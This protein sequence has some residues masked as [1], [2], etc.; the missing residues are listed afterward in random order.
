MTKR[1]VTIDKQPETRLRQKCFLQ[2]NTPAYESS[3]GV[4][5]KFNYY[6]PK[7]ALTCAPLKMKISLIIIIHTKAIV[8]PTRT[9]EKK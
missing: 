4:C 9:S 6:F 3:R 7:T 2:N 8:P 1:A 5:V